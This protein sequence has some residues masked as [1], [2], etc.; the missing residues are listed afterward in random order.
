LHSASQK[1]DKERRRKKDE[2]SE[3]DE[4]EEVPHRKKS[5]KTKDVSGEVIRGA[6]K[7]LRARKPENLYESLVNDDDTLKYPNEV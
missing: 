5:K 4:E 3:S 6:L 7:V 1:K 2:T